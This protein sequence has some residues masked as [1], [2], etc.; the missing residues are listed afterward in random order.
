MKNQNKISIIGFGNQAKAWAMNLRDSGAEVYIGHR[1]HSKSKELAQEMGF[2]TFNFQTSEVPSQNFVLLIPDD[3]HE[4]ALTEIA[5]INKD[6]TC[7]YAHGFSLT[8]FQLNVKF[9]MFKHILLAPKSIASEVR[10]LYE[11]KGIISAIYSNEF[12][13][14]ITKDE[15]AKFSSLVGF[16]EIYPASF[17]EE[18]QA[19][20]FSE[21]SILCS[22]LPYGA[23]E[24]YNTL[25][26]KGYPKELAF[27]ECFYEV[28]L[29]ADTLLKVGPQKFFELISPNA[30]IGSE[31][32]REFLFGPDFKDKLTKM[33]NQIEEGY[34]DSLIEKSNVE[35]LRKN[36]SQFWQ[37]QDL[38]QTYNRLKDR[39]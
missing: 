37:N 26:E 12:A 38:T 4:K 17:L 21:Q 25:V 9:P 16:K 19:D 15:I 18:T 11:T 10:F 39:L 34:F 27:F 8:R 22:L 33:L 14:E 6:K 1:P 2:K 20:L 35:E 32:G 7:Y 5:K 36:I 28:K 3:Q 31:V 30:L 23:L 13:P 24:T 29:I